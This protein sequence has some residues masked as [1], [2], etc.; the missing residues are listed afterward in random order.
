M[1]RKLINIC[2]ALQN[3][4]LHAFVLSPKLAC[5][6]LGMLLTSAL[7]PF[8]QIWVIFPSLAIALYLC[9]Q[10]DSLK[11]LIGLG[12]WFGFG[13]FAVGFYWI[14]NALLVDMAK[15][16]WLCPIAL[17]CNGAFFGI[18]VIFPFA[19]TKLSK[20][21]WAKMF[22]FSALWVL[23]G[24]WFRGIFLTGFPWNPLSSAMAISPALLQTLA[25]WGTY[26]LS[27]I[28]VLVGV[29]PVV[30]L[31]HPSRKTFCISA[32]SVIILFA[33]W[34]YG[35]FVIAHRPKIN[36]GKSIMVR[37][38]QPSIPQALKW[39]R[40]EAEKNLDAYIELSKAEDNRYV[41]FVIWGETASPYDFT[42]DVA[43][44]QRVKRAIPRKG[45]LISGFLRYE[46]TAKGYKPYNSLAVMDD[47]ANVI[48]TYD[49]SHL[50][51]FGEYIPLREFLPDWV[52]PVANNVAEFGRGEQYQTISVGEYPEF[53][54]LICYEV[55]FSDE[56]VRKV[57]KPKWMVVLTNDG[58]YG[59]S[60]GPYQHLV[61]AQM[62]AVEEGISVVRSANS[63]ISAIISPYGQ[64]KAK[65]A[66][67]QKGAID[68]LI[69]PDSAR[70]TLFGL[71]GNII[72]LSM[73]GALIALALLIELLTR[74]KQPD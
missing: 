20:N 7:P 67:G 44:R 74:R 49:Q 5:L 2:L 32:L 14:G 13:F 52:K 37:L 61:A 23:A 24:E 9:C 39:N 3:K 63:G 36:D 58:W 73:C 42:Y 65:L 18:F 69:K 54:P 66:L 4:C 43:H 11:R 10:T 27:L 55:I 26:G 62:R 46:P 19:V 17:F 28:V 35:G 38:V 51:P 34:N 47:K 68:M 45:Y 50:V 12:Y 71:Y 1:L 16:G 57:N 59:I 64:I 56:V 60:A 21:I 6:G 33:M 31:L 8:Y 41:D 70:N 25:W 22:L 72:P 29:L 48:A 30:W 15:T 40:E 53:A